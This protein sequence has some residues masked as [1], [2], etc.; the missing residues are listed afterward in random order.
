MNELDKLKD[1]ASD[2]SVNELDGLKNHREKALNFI[3]LTQEYLNNKG[4]RHSDLAK[5]HQHPSEAPTTAKEKENLENIPLGDGASEV[6][7][8]SSNKRPSSLRSDV[9]TKINFSFH[10]TEPT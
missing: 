8:V 4:F 5:S 9:M 3:Q 10:V 1:H 7:T 2:E 6:T